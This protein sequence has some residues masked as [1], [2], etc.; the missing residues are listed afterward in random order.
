M[1]DDDARTDTVT[2]DDAR[3]DA[4]ALGVIA[5]IHRCRLIML[6]QQLCNAMTPLSQRLS[7]FPISAFKTCTSL[8][9]YICVNYLNYRSKPIKLP[10]SKKLLQV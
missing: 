1:T 8:I 3:T 10:I 4:D 2:D 7:F 5:H 9:V 6:T